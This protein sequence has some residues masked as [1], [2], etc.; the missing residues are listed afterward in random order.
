[1]IIIRRWTLLA[2]CV[3][4][5]AQARARTSMCDADGTCHEQPAVPSPRTRWTIG[6]QGMR[7]WFAFH[8]ARQRGGGLRAA[9]AAARL[10]RRLH[11][12][13][14]AR[15]VR[16]RPSRAR[17]GTSSGKSSA[18][19]GILALAI[20]GDQ[21]QHALWRLQ[22]GELPRGNATFVLLIGT[23]NLGNGHLPGP[24]AEGVVAVAEALARRGRVV[25]AKIFPATTRIAWRRCARQRFALT[26]QPDS[27]SLAMDA[28]PGTTSYG[29]VPLVA[30]A[31]DATRDKL[32][33]LL[34]L[35]CLAV[36]GVAAVNQHGIP[37]SPALARFD[38]AAADEADAPLITVENK[39]VR[40]YPT[41]STSAATRRTSSAP[42]R[43]SGASP[44]LGGMDVVSYFSAD[45][46]VQG[47]A[48][49]TAT[50][51]GNLLRFSTTGNRDTAVA[52]MA[53]ELKH[54]GL[55]LFRTAGA[56]NSMLSLAAENGEEV[57][58]AVDPFNQAESNW[59]K[60]TRGN[61]LDVVHMNANDEQCRTDY[62][63]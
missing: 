55:W 28:A 11:H 61:E 7:E 58:D 14:V 44:L 20:S 12:G 23:N 22:H 36:L 34:L 8:Q 35:V 51:Q 5:A 29:A 17:R 3:S 4:V 26:P 1:M 43:A 49:I 48:L 38:E 18:T 39:G 30:P 32:H 52:P 63:R 59:N 57:T 62:G 46:P 56:K 41:R 25:V 33:G 47:D 21:T 13:D 9:E 19:G 37:A 40:G 10:R 50:Y 54:D 31:R 42:V 53:Y 24:T 27:S 2:A 45:T 6:T 60:L 15:H 16:G